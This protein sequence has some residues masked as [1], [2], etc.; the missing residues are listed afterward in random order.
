MGAGSGAQ[1]SGLICSMSATSL[2]CTNLA[3]ARVRP[4]M[5][6]ANSTMDTWSWGNTH[7][8][9]WTV[10]GP[11]KVAYSTQDCAATITLGRKPNTKNMLGAAA[12]L[13]DNHNVN[14]YDYQIY[15]QPQCDSVPLRAFGYGGEAEVGG[16]NVLMKG[17]FPFLTNV[18]LT[19]Y[20]ASV[21]AHE[22]GHLYGEGEALC[23]S[24]NNRGTVA[25]CDSS[26]NESSL[27]C[28]KSSAVLG[29]RMYCSPHDIMG[30]N[31]L[32]TV[33]TDKWMHRPYAALG[34][35]VFGWADALRYPVLISKV[36]YDHATD[37]HMGCDPNCTFWLQRSDAPTLDKTA[38]AVVIL[39]TTHSSRNGDH[40]YY[41]FE[42]RLNNSYD[43]GSTAPVLQIHWTDMNP[44]I[45]KFGVYGHLLKAPIAGNWAHL[46]GPTYLTDC[47]PETPSWDDAGCGL[48]QN[49]E[50]DTG[51]EGASMKMRVDIHSA[52]ESEKLKV[53]LSRV[54]PLPP[55][56]PSPLPPSPSPSSFGP[57]PLRDSET[58][59]KIV[60][61]RIWIVPW[62]VLVVLVVALR[63]R[64]SHRRDRS[65]LYSVAPT[66]DHR[67]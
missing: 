50:L 53:T 62:I 9:S 49:I 65:H 54:A 15:W 37:R 19:E 24:D 60:R 46:Y 12:A 51:H 56:S 33:S 7:L 28:N 52:L 13:L 45:H 31:S 48:G 16:T 20:Y 2:V 58:L 66:A 18:D 67:L 44:R 10:V 64:C 25:W 6:R 3:R 27:A 14:D 8:E 29:F 57:P 22:I 17:P 41:V 35:I 1:I 23:I 21:T 38:T 26:V 39:Q 40:R 47:T 42:H 59:T 34:R 11:Y 30:D 55:L 32:V 5:K 61:A 43:T 36:Y 63:R 4:Q